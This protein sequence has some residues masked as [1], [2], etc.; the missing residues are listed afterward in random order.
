M[1]RSTGLK[2]PGGQK[3][4][5]S[6]AD[7]VVDVGVINSDCITC[8]HRYGALVDKR[9]K[10]LRAL[11]GAIIANGKPIVREGKLYRVES[12]RLIVEAVDVVG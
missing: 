2:K 9:D 1:G 7:L 10:A 12:E 3:R 4:V 11:A 8:Q 6:L 5:K